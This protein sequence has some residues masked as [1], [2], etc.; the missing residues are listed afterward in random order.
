MTSTK[1]KPPPPKKPPQA[2]DALRFSFGLRLGLAFVVAVVAYLFTNGANAPN[3]PA[4]EVVRIPGKGK[5][6]IAQRDIQQG[7]LLIREKPLFR[8]PSSTTESPQ[9]LVWKLLQA[10]SAEGQAAFWDLSYVN[11]PET[12]TQRDH[13][14]LAIFETNAVAAGQQVGIFPGM[15]RLNHGCSSAFNAVYTWRESEQMLYVHA[16]RN[17]S[18]GQELLTTY[19]DT[20]RPRNE[21][22]AF[23]SSHY[24]FECTCAVCSLDNAGSLASDRR[25]TSISEF[26]RYFATWG[27]GDITGVEAIE[28]INNIWKLEEEEGYWSERGRLA[29]DAVWIAAAHSDFS[30]VRS[31]ARLAAK[32]Y[33]IEL[34]G[35]SETVLE[36]VRFAANPKAHTAWNSREPLPVGGPWPSAG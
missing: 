32:W 25:L 27:N 26:Y 16:L 12:V 13:V 5:G 7:E 10:T 35:D 28:A 8:V 34:G 15:A 36:V 22:R 2:R 18:K 19:T 9:Q 3:R 31:W 29:A 1:R 23:L 33:T 24:G 17:I 11:L 20:K 4:F 30:A 14:A 6:L 21:R